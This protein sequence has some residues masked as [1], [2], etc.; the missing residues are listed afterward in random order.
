MPRDRRTFINVADTMPEHPKIESLSDA[1]FRALVSLWCYCGRQLNDGLI[2]EATWNRRT[3]AKIRRELLQNGLV[4]TTPDGVL[5]HDYLEHNRSRAEAE[6]LTEKR[7]S[8]G[9][10][11]GKARAEALASAT[12]SATAGAAPGAKQTASNGVAEERRGEEK[13]EDSL[14]PTADAAEDQPTRGDVQRICDRMADRV[15][16]NTGKRPNI[17]KAWR[18]A[19][20]LLL[21]KDGHTEAQILWLIDWA[22][23]DEFW[24]ANILSLPKFREKF[25]Q[26]RLKAMAGRPA[27]TVPGAPAR[28]VMR[29]Q[30]RTR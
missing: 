21:D 29:D 24:R 16:A 30:W 6:G 13:R 9:S 26:L 4:E 17:V 10:L 18:D 23:T 27:G 3:S 2:P 7:R 28:P 5:M 1:S 15:Q 14:V 11:G 22:T 20:R 12:A 8:A 19:A 25:E